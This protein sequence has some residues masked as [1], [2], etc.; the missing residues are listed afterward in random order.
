M[1]KKVI[2][3]IDSLNCG[4]A[5]KSMLSLLPLLHLENYDISLWVLN[6]GGV[7]E[8]L[9]PKGIHIIDNPHYS[10]FEKTILKIAYLIHS[11]YIRILKISGKKQHGAES[12]WKSTGWA[13]KGLITEYDVAIAYQQGLPTYLVANRIKAKKKLAWINVDIFK[14][15]YN[16]VFNMSFYAKCDHIIAVSNILY[17]M[18]CEKMPSLQEKY[19]IVYDILNPIVIREMAKEQI[20][21][22]KPT[23]KLVITTVGRMAT[24][25]N[26]PL[27]VETAK[28]LSDHHIDF[29]WY[30]VG[31][32]SELTK[33]NRMIEENQLKD[34]VIPVGL[35]SN[36]Y[37]YM[38][39]C[40]I[41]VQTSS[42]EGF[43][44]TI[45]EAKILGKPIISTDFDVVHDQ[46]THE[47]NGLICK[48]NPQSVGKQIIRFINDATLREIIIHH[49]LSE[50]NTTYKTEVI[51]VEHLLDE[52]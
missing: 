41:Y 50:E 12:L 51:K 35:K 4:G 24:P 15:G 52:N 13:R 18:L 19:T 10:I 48:M 2:F 43:G 37:P 40:D 42:F 23:N 28:Y 22:I 3:V 45:A 14:A 47:K 8:S 46:I 7:L 49:V 39:M 26:Y 29:C 25:K 27:A 17:D 1:K 33:V 6:R 36:P 21:E 34:K 32:G 20:T 16:K 38:E 30:F 31:A 44:L 11:A 5:E 9:V